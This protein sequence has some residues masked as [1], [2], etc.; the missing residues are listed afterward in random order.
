MKTGLIVFAHGSTVASANEAVCR[1]TAEV[2]R[3]GGAE[4]SETAFLESAEPDLDGAVARLLARGASRIVVVPY[5]LVPGTH[6][7]RDLPRL[8]EQARRRNG[9]P[10][11]DVTPPLDGHPGLAAIVIDRFR[12]AAGS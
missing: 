10:Q 5:F 6:L 9:D 7:Q 1:V 4:L 12:A 2:A 11:I 8:V 3:Q